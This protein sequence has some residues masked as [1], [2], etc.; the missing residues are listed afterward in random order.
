M[1]I[2]EYLEKNQETG[3]ALATRAGVNPATFWKWQQG[4]QKNLSPADALRIS[5]ATGHDVTVLEILYPGLSFDL[6]AV[7][8][9]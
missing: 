3:H 8:N 9:D 7:P 2:N 6:K 5:K 1:K 4:Q